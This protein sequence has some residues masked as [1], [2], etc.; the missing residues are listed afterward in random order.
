LN[1]QFSVPVAVGDR[2]FFSGGGGL[3]VTDGTEGGTVALPVPPVRELHAAVDRVFGLAWADLVTSGFARIYASDGT[4]AGSG[5][6][7]QWP[8]VAWEFVDPE[9]TVV[10]ATLFFPFDDGIHGRELWSSDGT[11]AGTRL[12][13]DIWA[14][15]PGSGTQYLA[16]AGGHLYFAASDGD[17]GHELWRSDG[18]NEGTV[19]VADICPGSCPS[20]PRLLT[21]VGNTVYFDADDG[22]TGRQLW[23]ARL[24]APNADVVDASAASAPWAETVARVEVALS[25]PPAGAA[26]VRFET[27]DGSA[28]VGRDYRR[29][30]GELVFEP[31]GELR[32]VIE[33]PLVPTGSGGSFFVHLTAAQGAVIRR[34]FGE[35]RVTAFGGPPPRVRTRVGTGHS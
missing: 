16:A 27:A 23:A 12:V 28:L 21:A 6:L 11:V 4:P 25:E 2:V 3:S 24:P 10:D 1:G 32:Q 15:P 35:V 22:S 33:V 7:A 8:A 19:M 30:A 17:A 18:T 26:V 9:L 14:G 29:T 20:L 5:L 13:R 31:D 34:S